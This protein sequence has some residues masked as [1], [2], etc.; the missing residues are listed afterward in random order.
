MNAR[1]IRQA[2]LESQIEKI[3][4]NLK[5]QLDDYKEKGGGVLVILGIIVAAYVLYKLISDDDDEKP[6]QAV[7]SQSI[8]TA[9]N[10]SFIKNA[11]LGVLSSVAIGFARE[12]LLGLIETHIINNPKEEA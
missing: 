10:E 6:R 11:V 2:N 8:Q 12:K 5:N 3:S 1:E 4:E 9:R 7:E